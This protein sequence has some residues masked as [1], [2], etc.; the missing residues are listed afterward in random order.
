MRSALPLL[1][2]ILAAALCAPTPAAAIS[3]EP[4]GLGTAAKA[5]NAGRV[6]ERLSGLVATDYE[7][8][9][10]SLFDDARNGTFGQNTLIRAAL[11][12][13]GVADLAS[14]QA[15]ERE[16]ADWSSEV[17][18]STRFAASDLERTRLVFE[19]MHRRIL[20][21]EYRPD[22]TNVSEIFRRGDYN[23]VSSAILFNCLATEA[24]LQTTVAEAPGHAIS[25]VVSEASAIDVETTCPAWFESLHNHNRPNT[26]TAASTFRELSPVAVIA[27]VYY[28]RGV[29][30]TQRKDFSAAI[31]ANLKAL[32]LD[33]GS[34]L[35]WSNLLAALNN[36]SLEL[37]AQARYAEALEVL[38][39]GLDVAPGHA[40]FVENRRAIHIQWIDSLCRAGKFEQALEMVE[41]R[42]RSESGDEFFDLAQFH[43][44]RQWGEA[45]ASQRSAADMLPFFSAAQRELAGRAEW[46][47]T[48]A[49]IVNTAALKLLAAGQYES[50]I[51]Y[52]EL[53]LSRQPGQPLLVEN[54]R[55]AVMRWADEAFARRDFAE[56]IRRTT[57]GSA[58]GQLHQPMLNNLRYAYSEWLAEARRA[59]QVAEAER[60]ARL[61]AGDRFLQVA[62]KSR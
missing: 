37:T 2:C 59:G 14:L 52:F 40:M 33:P 15:F 24:G 17:R 39:R 41:A 56:A 28:N 27:L 36:W 50:A 32:R 20:R 11:V 47:E 48:E 42:Q 3:T 13:S 58:P 4:R 31:A 5:V 29:E 7:D 9:E 45:L 34:K 62:A 43:I 46:L 26:Q 1:A 30:A 8:L 22:C 6:A 49:A 19:F 57:A 38:Q 21:G 54:R 35:A 60:I 10:K 53:G 18:C 51:A 16:F 44:Y 61:A 23:C 25:R 55:V 12:A